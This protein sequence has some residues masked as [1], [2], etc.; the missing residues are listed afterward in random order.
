MEKAEWWAFAALGNR[1]LGPG[2]GGV[3]KTFVVRRFNRNILCMNKCL[4]VL[5]LGAAF[6][7]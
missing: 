3:A 7:A 5:I 2:R 1:G 4:L 6:Y